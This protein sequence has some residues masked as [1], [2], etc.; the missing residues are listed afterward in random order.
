MV[1][2]LCS[3]NEKVVRAFWVLG[4]EKEFLVDKG[5][6]MRSR[7]NRK[8]LDSQRRPLKDMCKGGCIEQM[9]V[10]LPSCEVGF[11]DRG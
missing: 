10:L 8:I 3:G 5:G 9:C 11:Q 2:G 4:G 6:G 7:V 1:W